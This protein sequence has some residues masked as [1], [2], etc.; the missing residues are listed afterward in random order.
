[1][2]RFNFRFSAV[3]AM[4]AGILADCAAKAADAAGQLLHRQ[5]L[6]PS[7][8]QSTQYAGL[9]SALRVK[10]RSQDGGTSEKTMVGSTPAAY[11]AQ[12]VNEL[13]DLFIIP[14]GSR[15]LP[16]GQVECAA[17]AASSTLSI[18][19]RTRAAGT[20]ISA[21][22][23]ASAVNLTAAGVKLANNGSI[24]AGG[25][26]IATEDLI[27]YA[28]FTGAINTANQAITVYQPLLPMS[29]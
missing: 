21:T 15:I 14:A 29:P 22:A 24:F 4:V 18:G 28:T 25:G 9:V 12:A 3:L 8:I 6:M 7:A 11:A 2:Q 23:I 5:G 19:L 13:F 17:G 20:V 10:I 26:Y 16:F 1:M 27:A